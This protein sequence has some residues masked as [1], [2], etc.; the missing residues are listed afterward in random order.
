[1]QANMQARQKRA[2]SQT[3]KLFFGGCCAA[4]LSACTVAPPVAPPSKTAPAFIPAPA[5]PTTAAPAASTNLSIP[6]SASDQPESSSGYTAKT[7]VI[8][9]EFIVATANP[10][11]TQAAYDVLAQGGSAVDAAIAAQMVLTLVE[12]QSSGIGGGAFLMAFDK[13]TKQTIAWDGRETAP[14]EANENLFMGPD[15]KPLKFADALVGGRSVGTP[16]VLR[17]LEAA[18]RQHGVL[19][20]QQLF[21]HAITLA[22]DGFLVSPRLN[23]MLKEETKLTLDTNAAAYFYDAAG[24]PWPVGHRLKNPVLAKTLERIANEGSD[25]FYV[26]AIAQKLVLAVQNHPTNPGRLSVDDLRNY[27]MIKRDALCSQVLAH[28]V[29][30]FPPPSS[31]GI[32]IAQMLSILEATKAPALLDQQGQLSSNGIHWFSEA[33]RLAF[34]DRNQYIA[35]PAFTTWPKGLLSKT[36]LNERAQLIKP[37]LSLQSAKPGQPND[38]ISWATPANLEQPSTSHLAI[39]DKQ[40]NAVSMTTTIEAAFGSRMMVEGFLL[41][42]QLTDFSFTPSDA[43]GAV[44]NRVQAQKRPRSSMAPTIVFNPDGTLRLVVGS[45]GGSLII[46]FVAKVLV[47]NL[48]DGIDIQKAIDLPNFGSRNGPTEIE[49]T[50]LSPALQEQIIKDLKAL[51]HE[52]RVIDMTSGLQGLSVQMDSN[53]RQTLTGGADPRREGKVMGR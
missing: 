37:N 3:V 44:A 13:K 40:G 7:A 16:G 53:G 6:K 1:M 41:N 11:S 19:P 33:G 52:V 17:M 50:I 35:D 32:A 21:K 25:A 30:G 34:A 2:H 49:S 10:L 22:K 14:A 20:W 47:A 4:F 9:R 24:K 43:Q 31:G 39:I 42:N 12:P 27:K 18:H 48:R 26:G 51:G 45:P 46:N 23:S 8:A 5:P 38:A 29:C 28:L 36:Y 15:G